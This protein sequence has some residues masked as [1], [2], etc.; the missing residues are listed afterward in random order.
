MSGRQRKRAAVL[1]YD[2]KGGDSAPRV[3]AKGYGLVAERIIER[4]RDAGLY[5]HTAPEMVSLLM[6]VDLDARIPPQLY[7][8]VAELLAWL[9]ALESGAGGDGG[10][11][12]PAFPPLPTRPR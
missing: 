2:A 12:Q 11:A 1:A 4:A 5:V 10:G 7:Q 9:Y 8:A 6:Q 3:V